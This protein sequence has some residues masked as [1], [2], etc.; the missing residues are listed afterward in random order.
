M[1]TRYLNNQN[2][3]YISTGR[4]MDWSAPF[5]STLWAF[6]KNIKRA[7]CLG[8]ELSTAIDSQPLEWVSKYGSV[9]IM[10]NENASCDGINTEGL[11]ANALWQEDCQYAEMEECENVKGLSVLSFV[12]YLLDNFKNVR[13][14][15]NFFK[16]MEKNKTAEQIVLVSGEVK[17]GTGETIKALL[18]YSVSD[19]NG[20]SAIIEIKEGK[21]SI[22]HCD[23]YVVMTNEPFYE[24]QLE[25][26]KYWEYQ[27][28]SQPIPDDKDK[29]EVT[30]IHANNSIPGSPFAI[31]RFARASFYANQSTPPS[32]PEDSVAQTLSVQMA[33]STPIAINLPVKSNNGNGSGTQWT[34]V[35]DQSRLKY[36][37]RNA[38]TPNTIWV[39]VPNMKLNDFDGSPF[40]GAQA[41]I[42]LVTVECDKDGINIT[43]FDGN[44]SVNEK[45]E[46]KDDPYSE[47]LTKH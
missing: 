34:T 18:H 16:E 13:E 4:N 2:K 46:S 23:E 14:V 35:I 44:G 30:Y 7:G 15:A 8:E 37:F 22:H 25:L 9:V 32:S 41:A 19:A 33:I 11:M 20:D 17:T 28:K 40:E 45:F 29:K 39:D 6:K 21:F 12:Q 5:D 47:Y 24:K 10:V 42:T 31:D 36:Y 38:R 27:W 43:N 3:D 1:C 26:N